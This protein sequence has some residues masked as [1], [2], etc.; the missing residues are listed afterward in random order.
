MI[1]KTC[2]VQH[3]GSHKCQ[4][5]HYFYSCPECYRQFKKRGLHT[6]LR[7]ILKEVRAVIVLDHTYHKLAELGYW[8]CIS[9]L[10]YPSDKIRKRCLEINNDYQLIKKINDELEFV[11]KE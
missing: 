2:Q 10:N 4:E 7:A 11:F 8:T 6:T 3:N 9:S 5:Q 1:C